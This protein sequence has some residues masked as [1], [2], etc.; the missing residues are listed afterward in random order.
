[1]VEAKFLGIPWCGKS[2]NTIKA[3][4]ELQKKS[5]ALALGKHA[6]QTGNWETNNLIKK[7]DGPSPATEKQKANGVYRATARYRYPHVASTDLGL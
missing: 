4:C 5:M 1:L 3:L 2:K 7:T 6:K